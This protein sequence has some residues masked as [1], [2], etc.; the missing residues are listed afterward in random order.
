MTREKHT[1]DVVPERFLEQQQ[2]K[3]KDNKTTNKKEK[4]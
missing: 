3:T 1:S 4:N 2:Q